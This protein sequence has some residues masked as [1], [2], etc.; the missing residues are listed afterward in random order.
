MEMMNCINPDIELQLKIG[1]K[2][3]AIE[4]LM[5][6]SKLSIE[7]EH[8]LVTSLRRLSGLDQEGD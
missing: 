3:K 4:L 5:K 2:L 6:H 8:M 1:N 7:D